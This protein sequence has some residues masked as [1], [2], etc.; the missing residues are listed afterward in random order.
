MRKLRQA[1]TA[2]ITF[3]V[4]TTLALLFGTLAHATLP[5]RERLAL[6]GMLVGLGIVT[7]A[8]PLQFTPETKIQLHTSV[9]FATIILFEP[10][11]AM[12]VASTGPLLAWVVRRQQWDLPQ[13]LFNAAQF[14]LQAGVG[15]LILVW[16]GWNANAPPFAL[17]GVAVWLIVVAAVMYVVEF[18]SVATVIS[19]ESHRPPWQVLRE[20][21][22]F[23][24]EIV[25][26]FALGLLG[27]LIAN[28]S[29]WALPL[30]LP[31]L[32][33]IYRSNQRQIQL[34]KQTQ[35]LEYQ[36]FHDPLTGL[37][38]RALFL[39]R[40]QHALHR[41]A[42]EQGTLAV[43]FLDVDQFKYINDSLG[44]DAGDQL[45]QSV[46]Q[47]LIACVRPADTVARLGGDEFTVLLEQIEPA[48]QAM[49]VTDRIMHALQ[50]PF[51]V[52]GQAVFVSAS[53]GITLNDAQHAAPNDL[54]RQADAAMY[55][56]KEHGRACYQ[57]FDVRNDAPA[58]MRLQLENE[59]RQALER[60]EFVVYYQPLV[61]LASGTIAGFEALARWAHPRHGLVSP[62]QFI[63]LA[64]D[65]G[66]IL[67]LGQLVLRTA[68]Q[69]AQA[70]VQHLPAGTPLRISVNLS[71]RQF[72][73]AGLVDDVAQ[74]L[75]D[76]GLE[77]QHLQL[78]ITESVVM[79]GA[80]S[81]L[82]TLQKLKR[83]GVHLAIDDFG[84]G[85]SSLSYLKH[86]PVDTLKI[87]RTFVESL[88]QDNANAAIA[89]AIITLAQTLALHTVAEG[90]ETPA[91]HQTLQALGCEYGQGFLWAR[92]LPHAAATMLLEDSAIALSVGGSLS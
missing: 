24:I 73:H 66:L 4:L 89:Q 21:S 67:P 37:A 53:I 72:Q 74:A 7:W 80:S 78:E 63:P 2:Y 39:E 33:V 46:A 18:C 85:Y 68:C 90:V 19:L 40:V 27:A 25:S 32:M 41:A 52:A 64:E 5:S 62:L 36:A 61:D 49:V 83:L 91:Q 54:L 77:P 16:A 17:L 76:T 1:T 75:R 87:D 6:A 10:G 81:A 9:L 11:I 8:F 47:R 29:I 71:A 34:R 26:Q 45:L 58:L 35:A 65:T 43:L 59:L 50:A 31:P 69:Q 55:K 79:H 82:T 88:A 15:G 14:M 13:T 20:I 42:R 30:L 84:T 56:A 38:N 51:A 22:R 44:H 92:P 86:F 3:V 60:Q 70:W 57:V 23:N 28:V 48:D 12:L